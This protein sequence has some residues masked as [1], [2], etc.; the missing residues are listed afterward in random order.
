[1]PRR[2]HSVLVY[3]AVAR[4][5][6]RRVSTY[7]GSSTRL[8]ER[9]ALLNM[10]RRG[11]RSA[12]TYVILAG[13][14]VPPH[15]RAS[16][17]AAIWKRKRRILESRVRYAV[18]LASTLGL[19]LLVDDECARAYNVVVVEPTEPTTT[20]TIVDGIDVSVVTT[21]TPTPAPRRTPV[22]QVAQVTRRALTN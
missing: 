22:S 19:P 8:R 9:I 3:I 18:T 12:L 2:R 15:L 13:L 20:T 21:T 11:R 17:L 7:I 5:A 1:M 6:Q 16:L 14:V 10:T 4:T